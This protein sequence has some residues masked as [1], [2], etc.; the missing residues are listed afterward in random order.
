MRSIK[1]EEMKNKEEENPSAG[2][3]KKPGQKPKTK[4]EA[5]SHLMDGWK[6]AAQ[7]KK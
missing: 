7:Y 5:T 4:E 6:M 2:Q 3:E 1:T